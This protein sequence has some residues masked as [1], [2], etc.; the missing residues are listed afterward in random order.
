MSELLTGFA[1]FLIIE[2]LVYALAP[3]ALVEMAK[4][5]PEIPVQQLRIFGLVSVA[6]GVGLV[7]MLRG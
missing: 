1:F 7:W 3:L 2:G 6:A 5:L 4:R